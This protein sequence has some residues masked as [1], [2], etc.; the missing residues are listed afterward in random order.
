VDPAIL[1]ANPGFA[2]PTGSPRHPSWSAACS[3]PQTASA[4]SRPWILRRAHVVDAAAAHVRHRRLLGGGAQGVASRSQGTDA[5][6]F[7]TRAQYLYALN[8]K[9]DNRAGFG[10]GGKVDLNV[11][12]GPLKAFAGAACLSSSATSSSSVVD[13]RAGLGEEQGGAARR[14]ARTTSTPAVALDLPHRP[15]RR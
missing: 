8:P 3:T 6:I 11:G 2:S 1:S 4:S 10:D 12:L 9:T 7:S 15:A 14:C 13:A 5:R